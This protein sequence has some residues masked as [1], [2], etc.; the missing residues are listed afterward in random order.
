[1]ADY[2]AKIIPMGKGAPVE[3]TGA[4]LVPRRFPMDKKAKEVIELI[5]KEHPDPLLE[6]LNTGSFDPLA[7]NATRTLYIGKINLKT[8][9]VNLFKKLSQFGKL[10]KKDSKEYT[11]RVSGKEFLMSFVQYDD[12][13]S[14]V[15]A[16]KVMAPFVGTGK[17]LCNFAKPNPNYAIW[18]GNV[19]PKATE[20]NLYDI[21]KHGQ[22]EPRL[23]HDNVPI[24]K[25][26][27]KKGHAVIKFRDTTTA[28]Q[29]YERLKRNPTF[30]GHSLRVDYASIELIN[31][32]W[33]TAEMDVLK[34]D[35]FN[36][37]ASPAQPP[38]RRKSP[39]HSPPRRPSHKPAE[40]KSLVAY[41][42]DD[43]RSVRED[44]G[45]VRDRHQRSV[46]SDR[47]QTCKDNERLND[48]SRDHDRGRRSVDRP[49]QGQ[50]SR[51][52][53]DL[54][55]DLNRRRDSVEDDR[56]HQE[57]DRRRS[58]IDD[59]RDRHGHRVVNIVS[60]V[61]RQGARSRSKDNDSDEEDA[62]HKKKKERYQ[63][64]YEAQLERKAS[65]YQEL[66][67]K[68]RTTAASK[69]ASKSKL[70]RNVTEKFLK[71][72]EQRREQSKAKPRAKS[73]SPSPSGSRR[74]MMK[75]RRSRSPTLTKV[76]RRVSRSR[77]RNHSRDHSTD[78]SRD[79]YSSHPRAK[80]GKGRS[81]TSPISIG[82]EEEV[83]LHRGMW[84]APGNQESGRSSHRSHSKGSDSDRLLAQL[85]DSSSMSGLR[86]D[87]RSTLETLVE[88]MVGHARDG[89]TGSG[90]RSRERS[91]ERSRRREGD[92]S[93][94]RSSERS[95]E[96]SRRRQRSATPPHSGAFQDFAKQLKEQANLGVNFFASG[97]DT[98]R[99]QGA[100]SSQGSSHGQY[101]S[102]K[103][104]EAVGGSQYNPGVTDS[105]IAR[106]LN[107]M[108]YQLA[109]TLP[110]PIPPP[111]GALH[112][113]KDRIGYLE[114][115]ANKM[116]VD[117]MQNMSRQGGTPG[118]ARP[119][120]SSL[121]SLMGSMGS[122]PPPMGVPAPGGSGHPASGYQSSGQL[123]PHGFVMNNPSMY[124]A[125]PGMQQTPNMQMPA[126]A[127]RPSYLPQPSNNMPH[128]SGNIR[129]I[130]SVGVGGTWKPPQ[131]QQQQQP[132]RAQQAHPTDTQ[133]P[134][135]ASL[136]AWKK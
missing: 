63:E 48:G 26:D 135:Q 31:Q 10:L 125:T 93:M 72:R 17:M 4:A 68:A 132:S 9:T 136:P 86:P 12:I 20:V 95:S 129:P 127:F 133:Y 66:L 33:T 124:M 51:G 71:I 111:L 49:L 108:N 25:L 45:S 62:K 53:D 101:G 28:T 121:P 60:K 117:V 21:V 90:G 42:D 102:S 54:R 30:M 35:R 46:E 112:K 79:R 77:S 81:S 91:G 89:R 106:Q 59:T 6:T 11:D 8:K 67:K 122:R 134:Y 118:T 52:K 43:D 27:K 14:V 73:R 107:Q 105:R 2:M 34:G 114:T 69:A 97:D 88:R 57:S 92:R 131:S 5:K 98:R 109:S 44:R 84:L 99:G 19:S 116:A 103:A 70:A 55:H 130:L 13:D 16:I 119:P 32:F 83:D 23:K 74:V 36:R 1:V 40:K 64:L 75:R 82:D 50:P 58:S 22:S 37:E 110:A 115:L 100:S 123:T 128:P 104:G 120:A 78:R 87:E 80:K 76:K 39:S 29:C 113:D 94:E 65:R 15:K 96:R 41:D 38:R 3:D 126:G 56:R 85:R 47:R 7:Y 61:K 24:V 18:L